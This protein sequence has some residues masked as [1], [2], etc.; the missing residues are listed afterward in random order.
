MIA[1]LAIITVLLATRRP[2]ATTS[3]TAP[4]SGTGLVNSPPRTTPPIAMAHGGSGRLTWTLWVKENSLGGRQTSPGR[5]LSPVLM[6]L[7][8]PGLCTFVTLDHPAAAVEGGSGGG[9]CG[10]PRESPRFSVGAYGLATS[11]LV[12][13]G[14]TSLPASAVRVEYVA[15]PSLTVAS[16][17]PMGQLSNRLPTACGLALI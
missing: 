3:T 9:T 8:G 14:I 7:S 15:S 12:V 13:E 16:R 5:P 4:G 6:M 11:F 17:G 2:V 1:L 10:D